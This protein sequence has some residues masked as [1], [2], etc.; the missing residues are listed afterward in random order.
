M[1]GSDDDVE[2]LLPIA[3]IYLNYSKFFPVFNE[4]NPTEY[5]KTAKVCFDKINPDT[6]GEGAGFFLEYYPTLIFFYTMSL[7]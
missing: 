5:F 1:Y 2:Y 7:S 3:K 4:Y 6:I